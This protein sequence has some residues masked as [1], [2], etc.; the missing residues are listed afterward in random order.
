MIH[1]APDYLVRRMTFADPRPCRVAAPDLVRTFLTLVMLFSGTVMLPQVVSVGGTSGLGVWTILICAGAWVL[2]SAR[3]YFPR[4]MASVLLPLGFFAVYATTSLAWGGVNVVALQNLAVTVGFL[5]FVLLGAR[6]S[7]RDSDFSRR[8]HR[9]LDAASVVAAVGY[10]VTVL[11]RGPGGELFVGERPLFLSR[12][13]A[14]F[15]TLAAARQIARWMAGDARGLWMSVWLTGLIVLSHSRLA[16]VA[17]LA[18][19]PLGFFLRGDR[20]GAIKAFL[21][22]LVGSAVL[23]GAVTVSE[24][25]RQRFF[26]YDASM[27]IGGVAFN[28]SGRTRAWAAL[29]ADLGGGALVFGKGAGESSWFVSER[30]E[31]LTHPHNDFL[32]FLYDYGAFGL[33]WWVLFLAGVSWVLLRLVRRAALT[34]GTDL[35]VHMTPILALFGIGASMFTD[36]SISY[37]FVMAPLGMLIGCSLSRPAVAVAPVPAPAV[38]PA[39]ALLPKPFTAP[40]RRPLLLPPPVTSEQPEVEA[41][42]EA[43]VVARAADVAAPTPERPP[44]PVHPHP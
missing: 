10:T 32:R 11:L 15:A 28:A 37:I 34:P 6:E 5:G 13:F 17:T 9:V 33:A 1:T 38:A 30:F 3:P 20:G 39:T 14:L 36:N 12:P 16:M 25:L 4:E 18:L 26:G 42:S 24:E 31:N 29:A 27:K 44:E 23:V 35:P 7:E 43:P 2:W 21:M 22:L 41:V 19:F 8:L 40:R